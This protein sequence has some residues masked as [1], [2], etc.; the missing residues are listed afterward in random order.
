MVRM[1]ASCEHSRLSLQQEEWLKKAG[2][3]LAYIPSA[4]VDS[5]GTAVLEKF[6]VFEMTEH[7]RLLFLDGD[8][9]PLCDLE[10]LFQ[11]S[12]QPD[13]YHSDNVL[14]SGSAAPV[15]ACA[16]LVT[17]H[18]GLFDQ[19]LDS[20]RNRPNKT[21]FDKEH[22]WG[23]V[24]DQEDYRRYWWGGK[25]TWDFK[26]VASDQGIYPVEFYTDTDK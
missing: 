23:L 1:A 26:A 13:G 10:Y 16:F 6:R 22:G 21:K 15:T 5:F 19:V 7:D 20:Y 3:K 25:R 24:M 8:S 12:Y 11:A 4:Q 9:I 18:D 14:T 17:P 2:V